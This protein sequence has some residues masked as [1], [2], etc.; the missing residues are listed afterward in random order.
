[1]LEQGDLKGIIT[2]RG[3][4]TGSISSRQRLLGSISPRGALAATITMRGMMVAQITAR[5]SLIGSISARGQLVGQISGVKMGE[6]EYDT[7]MLVYEDGTELPAV[8]V[9][10]EVTFTATEND[11]RKGTIA[12]TAKGVTEGT[13]E[14]PA[15]HI[16]QGVRIIRPGK[17]LDI[18]LYSDKCQYTGLNVIVC[19]YVTDLEDSVSAVMVVIN[20]KLYAVDSAVVISE[21]TVD[22]SAESIKLGIVNESD[23]SLLLR[24]MTYKEEP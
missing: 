16:Q 4:L 19:K 8:F 13:K 2:A 9:E 17:A 10:N 23:T 3:C 18:L 6:E 15:Y 14:I 20:D 1:M 5:E 21:V 11:I 12:A 7:Y 24:Y 22:T